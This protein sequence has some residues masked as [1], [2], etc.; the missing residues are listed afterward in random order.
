[1]QEQN[2]LLIVNPAA[3]KK[4]A[5]KVLYKIVD[6]LCRNKCKTTVFT[7]TKRGEAT[8]I[9]IEC[10]HE[11]QKIICCG[12]DGTLNEIISGLLPL[13]IQIPVGYIPTGT[14][15]DFA[16][17]LNLLTNINHAIEATT[18]GYIKY[19]DI[20][21]LSNVF[22]TAAIKTK[23]YFFQSKQRFFCF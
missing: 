9:V 13:N 2:I 8:N 12:G 18:N 15:N 10:A 4:N 5:N 14:M 1:M 11:C 20:E 22:I 19:H 16:Q 7:T 23:M 21:G 6:S 17:S 3:G